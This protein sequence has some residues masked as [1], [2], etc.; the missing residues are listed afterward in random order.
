MM[1]ALAI[2]FGSTYT[3]LVAID[4][5]R[6]KLVGTAQ[7][8]TTVDDINVGLARALGLL[9]EST[10]LR[11]SDCKVRVASSSAAGGLRMVAIGLVPDLTA[12]A[13]RRAALGAGA[14]ILKVYSYGLVEGDCEDLARLAPD[15]ILL[16][17]GT[18]GG[19]EDCLLG[20]ARL[21]AQLRLAAPV[22]VAG[23]RR[24]A[25]AAASM[26][27]ASG[28]EV[29]VVANVLPELGRLDVEPA[30]AE[31]Q[32]VFIERIVQ[33]KGL[34][35]ARSFVGSIVMPTPMAVLRGAQLLADGCTGAEGLG[36][37]VVVDVGGATTDVHSISD[38][39]PS[40]PKMIPRGLPEP[41][42][43]RTVEGDLGI[44]INARTIL[45]TV[46][47]AA[48]QSAIGTPVTPEILDAHVAKLVEET[49]YVPV[50]DL[51]H[52]VDAALARLAIDTA[53]SRHAGRIET[54]YTVEGP[55]SVLIGKDLS[56][57]R[58]VIGTGGIFAYGRDG[59]LALAGARHD[60]L[61]PESMR[62]RE[63]HFVV[64]KAYMLFAVGLLAD[65]AP[66]A[67]T[68]VFNT[69]SVGNHVQTDSLEA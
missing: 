69:Q 32:R 65:I 3:K 35:R 52:K 16:A 50:E 31:I 49:Q 12:E 66:Q 57:V 56:R 53:M 2:D 19:N 34:D 25:G 67:A 22:I 6:A 14:K 62:P 24:V 40:M 28:I 23:N 59:A 13:A 54:L 7:S 1:I 5:E 9:E 26:L 43:K 30:R 41:Y 55:V 36:D 27:R 42:A 38:G 17:G 68:R 15:I 21:L 44:R 4:I 11:A 29:S 46:G 60:A 64:D 47:F 33:A 51:A 20:N 39:A 58:T 48:M 45:E 63:P 37:I 18:D 8:P 10:S 61:T